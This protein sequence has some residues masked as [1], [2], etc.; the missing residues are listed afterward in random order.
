[1]SDYI[2]LSA[3]AYNDSKLTVQRAES[4][5]SRNVGIVNHTE[6][7]QL[8]VERFFIQNM[9]VPVFQPEIDSNND[10][11]L[12]FSIYDKTN[13]TSHPQVIRL[14]SSNPDFYTFQEIV[15]VLNSNVET[16][17]DSLVGKPAGADQPLFAFGSERWSL[18]TN[19]DFRDRYDIYF[20][21]QFYQILNS[22]EFES[23]AIA[24]PKEVN[25]A[26]VFLDKDTIVQHS[27][28]IE[29]FSPVSRIVVE[30][31]GIPVVPELL[32]NFVGASSSVNRID[33]N[34]LTDYKLYVTNSSAT[35]TVLYESDGSYRFFSL[36][37]S[38]ALRSFNVRFKWVSY[39]G[40]KNNIKL[41][42]GNKCEIKFL[43]KKIM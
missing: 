4:Q 1:M 10:T 35:Q 31:D 40:I 43:L 24:N 17:W 18:T 16:L 28:T 21:Q 38:E 42:Y 32:P 8:A 7:Y 9:V 29:Q 22:F 33:D 5:Q 23:L 30:A 11:L 2:Y 20:N 15:K 13:S 3:R 27:S 14:S 25:Y 41:D 19:Q 26:K 37:S 6:R 39:K 34:V 36:Q 12:T